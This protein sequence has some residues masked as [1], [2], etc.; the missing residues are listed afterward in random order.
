VIRVTAHYDNSADNPYNPDPTQE[1]KFG[2]QTW[3][4]MMW[5]M[6]AAIFPRAE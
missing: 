6:Y 4:E 2:E 3:E 5:G 1:V